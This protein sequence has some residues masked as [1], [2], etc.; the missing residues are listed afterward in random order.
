[1]TAA[2]AHM[3][4]I[5]A[6]EDMA[7][8]RADESEHKPDPETKN[9]NEHSHRVLFGCSGHSKSANKTSSKPERTS[10]TKLRTSQAQDA[11]SLAFDLPQVS[12]VR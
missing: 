4:V 9:V 8:E 7:E 3:P 6:A 12:L 10:T 11:G 1:M 5:S 2:A